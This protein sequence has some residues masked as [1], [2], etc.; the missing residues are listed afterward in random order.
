MCIA[1]FTLVYDCAVLIML[2][3]EVERLNM[4]RGQAVEIQKWEIEGTSQ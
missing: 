1:S 3:V 2:K 4:R